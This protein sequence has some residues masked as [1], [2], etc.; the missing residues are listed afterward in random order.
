MSKQQATC[1][2]LTQIFAFSTLWV[3]RVDWQR[4][5]AGSLAW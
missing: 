3:G 5:M 2:Q 4:G 1:H